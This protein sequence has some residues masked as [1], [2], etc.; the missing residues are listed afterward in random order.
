MERERGSSGLLEQGLYIRFGFK[1]QEKRGESWEAGACGCVCYSLHVEIPS[2]DPPTVGYVSRNRAE[3]RLQLRVKVCLC[4]PIFEDVEHSG[5]Y[6]IPY[7]YIS[8]L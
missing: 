4:M 6:P 1:S 8:M 5:L 7:I 3:I 2:S